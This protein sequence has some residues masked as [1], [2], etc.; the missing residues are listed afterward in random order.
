MTAQIDFSRLMQYPGSVYA[1][2]D[3]EG[4]LG[5]FEAYGYGAHFAFYWRT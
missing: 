1:F 3:G 4:I 2:E 5:W